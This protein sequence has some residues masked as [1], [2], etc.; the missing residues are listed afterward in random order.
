MKAVKTKSGKWRVQVYSHTDQD[1]KQHKKSFTHE[2]KKE[3]MRMASEFQLYR[4]L[5]QQGKVTWLDASTEY[6]DNRRSVLSPASIRGYSIVQNR[7]KAWD[8]RLVQ[9]ITD[10]DIQ[11]MVNYLTEN[12][13]P[14]TVLSTYKFIKVVLKQ[15]DRC[16]RDIV[17]PKDVK[18]DL[19]IP[20]DDEIKTL[21]EY[22]SDH[23]PD[24]Y[25]ATLCGAV[26]CMR[27]AEIAALK[28]SDLSDDNLLH[29]QRAMV[30]DS[31]RNW[32]IKST[33][34]YDSNRI[35]RCPDVL[36]NA[37]REAEDD[38]CKLH[39]MKIT[40]HF[41][42]AQ[43]R[44]GLHHFRFHD[45]RHYC[46]SRQMYANIPM[47]ELQAYGGWSSPNTLNRIYLHTMKSMEDEMARKR[48]DLFNTFE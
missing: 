2:S 41:V 17:L 45:L 28:K 26:G 23:E 48:N 1:G 40:R 16:P 10:K 13:A 42:D 20:S 38:V 35:I 6:I 24:M 22:F 8:K 11:K 15:Y 33:K 32:I 14:K 46:V 37:I 18:P 36:A 43:A 31:S 9:D 34:T 47:K 25:R 3:A 12:F 21:L 27:R 29:I 44:L 7:L 4:D 30:M 39:P 19:Y 5:A